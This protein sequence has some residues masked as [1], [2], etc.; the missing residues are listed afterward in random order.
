MHFYD[1]EGASNP[2]EHKN[3]RFPP[4]GYKLIIRVL[5]VFI[6]HSAI[7]G[8][9]QTELKLKRTVLPLFYEHEF[10]DWYACFQFVFKNLNFD[11]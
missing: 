11:K 1:C 2:K 9:L 4:Q 8:L 6:V 10:V 5:S 7:P 3:L